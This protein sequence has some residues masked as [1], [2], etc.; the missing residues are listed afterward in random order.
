[1]AKKEPKQRTVFLI[2]RKSTVGLA[3][4]VYEILD[5][6]VGSFHDEL[7]KAKIAMAWKNGWRENADGQM[8]LGQCKK[9]SDLDKTLHG[10]DFVILLNSGWVNDGATTKEQLRALIDHEL[11]HATIAVDDDGDPK[12]MADGSPVYRVRRHT[13][14]E[15]DEVVERHGLYK[16]DLERF[17]G[18]VHQRAKQD[19]LFD[20]KP[21]A[22]LKIAAG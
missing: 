19:G 3:R 12:E 1:M 22:P 18:T 6:L 17:A 20:E 13:I 11:C 8:K 15:F 7:A 16:R 21:A 4:Q 14:E 2:E 5:E 9:G 10:Y